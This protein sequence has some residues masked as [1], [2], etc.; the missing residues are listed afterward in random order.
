[1][2]SFFLKLI[3]LVTMTIDHSGAM[4]MGL[5]HDTMFMRII[6]RAAFPIYA[7]LIAEGCRKTHSRGK[8]FLRLAVFA[9][10]SEVAFD[11]FVG[12]ENGYGIQLFSMD[13]QNVFFTLAAG[14]AACMLYDWLRPKSA[15]LGGLAAIAI[16]FAAEFAHSDYGFFGVF[17]IVVAFLC[18]D[19]K[20]SALAVMG[21]LGGMY[22]FGFSAPLGWQFAVSAVAA[23]VLLLLYNGEAGPRPAW[24]KW[25]F[26][27]YYPLHLL[28]I[29]LYGLFTMGLIF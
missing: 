28:A 19:A 15:L 18:K 8:Y 27:A 2:T 22:L 21:I 14:A 20:G 17:A 6:G 26:Y 25:L 3:A 12:L 16:G 5:G 9:L 7:F 4:L 1:M 24:M 13:S 10:V 11:L 23:G 29:S